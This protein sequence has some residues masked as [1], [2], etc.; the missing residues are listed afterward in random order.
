MSCDKRDSPFKIGLLEIYKQKP[1]LFE[2]VHILN[3]R[4]GANVEFSRTVVRFQLVQLTEILLN[5]SV[6]PEKVLYFKYI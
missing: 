5:F 2:F 6:V 3:C 1:L 4:I